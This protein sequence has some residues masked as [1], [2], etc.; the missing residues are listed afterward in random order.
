[1]RNGTHVGYMVAADAPRVEGGVE[2]HMLTK[3]HGNL[4]EQSQTANSPVHVFQT[5]GQILPFGSSGFSVAS[6]Q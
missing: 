2:W 1:M 5:M 3:I 4:S 6:H